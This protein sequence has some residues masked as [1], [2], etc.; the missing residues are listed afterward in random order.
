MHKR[1]LFDSF[2]EC[3]DFFRPF[4]KTGPPCPWRIKPSKPLEH[5][6]KKNDGALVLE[7]SK[8]RMLEFSANLCGL[9]P[10]KEDSP[11]GQGFPIDEEYLNQIR[12]DRMAKMLAQEV[13]TFK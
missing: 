2:N 5:L 13:C 3:I 10:D 8:A 6:I 1:L 11:F 4:G 9:I 7:K 12:E